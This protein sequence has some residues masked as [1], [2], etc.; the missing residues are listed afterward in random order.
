MSTVT[1]S[2]EE[3]YYAEIAEMCLDVMNVYYKKHGSLAESLS[4]LIVFCDTM[5]DVKDAAYSA[6]RQTKLMNEYLDST[7]FN[8]ELFEIKI[9]E[10]MNPVYAFRVYQGLPEA[11]QQFP[12]EYYIDVSKD[13]Y[14]ISESDNEE[15]GPCPLTDVQWNELGKEIAYMK[16]MFLLKQ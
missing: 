7:P 12:F 15:S 5:Y 8:L 9:N 2:A 14:T 16:T 1:T 3:K 6:V 10:N 13:S 11:I 4:E